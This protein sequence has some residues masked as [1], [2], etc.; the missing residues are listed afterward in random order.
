VGTEPDFPYSKKPLE[1][2]D[3][4]IKAPPM[5]PPEPPPGHPPSPPPLSDPAKKKFT[6]QNCGKVFNTK[7][8]LTMHMET[9]HMTPKRKV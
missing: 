4:S 6:C 5:P 2:V 3:D 1:P 9:V 8:E 7:E